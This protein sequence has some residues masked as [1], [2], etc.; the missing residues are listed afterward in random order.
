MI[1]GIENILHSQRPNL[2]RYGH[3]SNH[4]VQARINPDGAM[5][6]ILMGM[7]VL[8]NSDETKVA[9]MPV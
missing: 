2:H 6:D 9:F 5:G 4:C 8:R 7:L 1:L 3:H